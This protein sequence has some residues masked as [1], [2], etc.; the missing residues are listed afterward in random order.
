[1]IKDKEITKIPVQPIILF[2]DKSKL[3][4]EVEISNISSSEIEIEM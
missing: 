3:S 4:S 1:M 2:K